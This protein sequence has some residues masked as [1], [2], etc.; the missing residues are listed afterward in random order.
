L[1][2]QVPCHGELLRGDSGSDRQVTPI[3]LYFDLVFV[4]AITQ[5]SRLLLEHLTPHG[6]LQTGLLLLAIG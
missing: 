6:A 3:E 2:Q 1:R 5:L 4:F